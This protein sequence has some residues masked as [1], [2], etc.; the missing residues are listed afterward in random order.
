[1]QPTTPPMR[2]AAERLRQACRNGYLLTAQNETALRDRWSVEAARGR[3]LIIHIIASPHGWYAI[4][5]NGCAVIGRVLGDAGRRLVDVIALEH[6]GHVRWPAGRDDVIDVSRISHVGA[7]IL[8]Y[9][10]MD[11]GLWFVL[12][13]VAR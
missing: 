6:G 13:E 3:K 1:M 7:S 10:I 2:P 4:R 9:R 8:V 12:S 11:L 5:A